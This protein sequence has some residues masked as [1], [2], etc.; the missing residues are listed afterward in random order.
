[1]AWKWR[2]SQLY[3]ATTRTLDWLGSPSRIDLI[4]K[5]ALKWM[6]GV[7]CWITEFTVHLTTSILHR[8]SIYLTSSHY[9]TYIKSSLCIWHAARVFEHLTWNTRA[10]RCRQ[11]PLEL[12]RDIRVYAHLRSY[13]IEKYKTYTVLFL[14]GE[15]NFW[16][17]SLVIWTFEMCLSKAS[18]EW[19][20]YLWFLF[21]RTTWPGDSNNYCDYWNRTLTQNNV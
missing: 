21:C 4:N 20:T 18:F 2:V 8:T 17:P 16:G 5:Y 12:T 11:F 19:L 10:A 3:L 7:N 14:L 1:M 6:C 9:P 15:L 13:Q